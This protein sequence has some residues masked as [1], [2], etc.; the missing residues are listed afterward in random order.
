MD[1]NFNLPVVQESSSSPSLSLSGLVQLAWENHP[2]DL[3][4]ADTHL[5]DRKCS[6][7][8]HIY[9][10]IS[11]AELHVSHRDLRRGFIR[12]LPPDF[13]FQY[14]HFPQEHGGY[15]QKCNSRYRVVRTLL[16]ALLCT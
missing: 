12:S 10:E 8:A 11:H 15:L 7:T 6:K 16:F 5:H 2:R 13:I 4:V 1:R 14:L 3:P 9:P